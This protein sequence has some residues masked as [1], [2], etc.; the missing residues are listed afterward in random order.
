VFN[1]HRSRIH[2]ED[3]KTFFEAIGANTDIIVAAPSNPRVSRAAAV[4]SREF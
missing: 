1:D 3:A 4:F 2:I